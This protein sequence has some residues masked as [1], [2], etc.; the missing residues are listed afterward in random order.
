MLGCLFAGY[1]KSMGQGKSVLGRGDDICPLTH[2]SATHRKMMLHLFAVTALCMLLSID[3]K[4][5]SLLHLPLPPPPLTSAAVRSSTARDCRVPGPA[6]GTHLAVV[7]IILAGCR[8][9]G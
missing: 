7:T 5:S 2:H 8:V 4:H 9:V 3:T 6:M 1:M